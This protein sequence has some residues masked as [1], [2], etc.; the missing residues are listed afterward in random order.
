L[1]V[2]GKNSLRLSPIYHTSIA[3]AKGLSLRYPGFHKLSLLICL[4][5]SGI[6]LDMLSP[7]D[8]SDGLCHGM[9]S[10]SSLSLFFR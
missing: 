1:D 7:Q 3:E 10:A 4:L 8:C 6:A 9:Q 5:Q 2:G